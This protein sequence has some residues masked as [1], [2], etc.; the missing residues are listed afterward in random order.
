MLA[1]LFQRAGMQEEFDRVYVLDRNNVIVHAFD[2]AVIDRNAF[3]VVPPPDHEK[4]HALID[5]TRNRQQAETYF[6]VRRAKGI[7][8]G[9]RVM[10]FVKI[11][12]AFIAKASSFTLLLAIFDYLN[13]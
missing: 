3:D 11:V 9:N 13:T 6:D 8:L 12:T 5:E 7:R 1:E 2:S 4:L 10:I